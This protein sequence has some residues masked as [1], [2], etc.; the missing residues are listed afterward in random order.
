MIVGEAVRLVVVA[1]KTEV[2]SGQAVGEASCMMQAVRVSAREE[3][4]EAAVH[5]Q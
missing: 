1:V 3:A 5:D 4:D 2:E